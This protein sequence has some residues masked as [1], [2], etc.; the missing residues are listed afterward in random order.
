MNINQ[1]KLGAILSYVVI[2]LNM[3]VGII[4]TPFLIRKLG[5]AEYGL[6]SI[7]HSIMLYL[8]VM[9]MGFG[10]AIV[11][12]TAR[13]IHKGE[14]DKQDKLHGM[15]FSIYCVIGLLAA[16]V[17]IILYFNI[18]WIFGNSM[19]ETEISKAKIMMLIL[20]INLAMTF[21]LSIF[22]YVI[23]AHEKFVISKT[24][25]IIQ[26]LMQPLL[27]IP[28]LIMGY[29]AI[30]MVIVLTI[31]NLFCLMLNAIV[32]IKKLKVRLTFKG[33]DFLLLKEIFAYSFYIFLNQIIDKINWSLDQ[34]IIGSIAGTIVTAVYA[35]A[36][37]LNT[38]YMNFSTAISGVMLPKVTKME[39]N[40][41]S[42]KEFS[43]VF[44]KTGRVQ[45]LLM[46]LIITGY[47]LFGKFFI[48]WW[49]GNGYED[50]YIIGCILMIPLTIPLI[51]NVGISILQAKNLYKYRTMIFL[52]IAVLNLAMSIPLT[53]LYGGIGAAIG[54]AT[55]LIL[56]QGIILNLYY[57]YKVG[58]DMKRFWINIIKMTIPVL[59]SI[60][61]G[62]ILNYLVKDNNLFVWVCKIAIY[63]MVFAFMMWVM[64]M[65][66]YE[67]N[68][69]KKPVCKIKN[70]IL[71]N[72]I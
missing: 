28:L 8:T 4:Y 6:F 27:M 53:K 54:T 13:Y 5:Q 45:Y 15:F 46:A 61:F 38:M 19:T 3:C 34:F 68:L 20:T 22:G 67:K 50:A 63:S 21:P 48:G 51:Q 43:E 30:A 58:I 66:E 41:C 29:K 16:V 47:I 2:V 32:A 49:A 24:I 10:N 37:Q 9:D 11:I 71:N 12:Y 26:I 17:G 7:I 57:N 70:K 59:I 35:I 56:G 36:G 23:T 52:G 1:R 60:L 55:S 69:F 18:S 42:N 62:L 31:S 39:T 44:I 40:K 25:K 64:A 65:N 33:F 72:K 14:K